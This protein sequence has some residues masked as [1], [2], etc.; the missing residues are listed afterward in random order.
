[1]ERRA[2]LDQAEE[3]R[4]LIDHA[5]HVVAERGL[6]VLGGALAAAIRH[7]REIASVQV[8]AQHG[9]VVRMHGPGEHGA[10]AAGLMT[11]QQHRLDGRGRP[12]VQRGVRDVHPG[13]LR[14]HALE[15]EDRGERALRH[16]RLIRRV[17]GRELGAHRQRVHRGRDVMVV[18]AAAEERWARGRV[19]RRG[20]RAEALPQL[21]LGERPGNR[22]R[23]REPRAL[24]HRGEELLERA[25]ADAL[26]H[27]A[28]FV[29]REPDE[30]HPCCS[31]S[32]RS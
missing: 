21:D 15:L 20:P 10:R 26:E 22:G 14:D 2:P 1:M 25:H 13:Q 6:Q 30:A 23:A 18:A 27:P 19:V 4:R 32:M 16:L 3:V 28:L 24:R 8:G 5:R 7:D 17:G 11:R 29:L 31:S 12:V 9:D